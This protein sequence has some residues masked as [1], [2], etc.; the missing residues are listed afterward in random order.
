M[1]EYTSRGVRIVKDKSNSRLASKKIDAAVA[2]AIACHR[3]Y[4]DVGKTQAA[5]VIIE[6]NLGERMRAWGDVSKEPPWL[7]EPF[8]SND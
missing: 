5:P 2:L 7:P 3:A 4:E 6:S 1:A 8:R